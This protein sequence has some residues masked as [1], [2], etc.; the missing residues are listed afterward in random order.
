MRFCNRLQRSVPRLMQGFDREHLA[1][2][3]TVGALRMQDRT[4]THRS[5]HVTL[6]QQS[7]PQAKFKRISHT[8]LLL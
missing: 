4:V 1:L 2:S 7:T 6:V 3:T 8:G 5:W